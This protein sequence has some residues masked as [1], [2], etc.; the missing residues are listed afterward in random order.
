M[1]NIIFVISVLRIPR[2]YFLSQT[3]FF[4]QTDVSF[5][6]MSSLTSAAGLWIR[7]KRKKTLQIPSAGKKVWFLFLILL[8]PHWFEV[9]QLVSDAAVGARNN[10]K[11]QCG[12]KVF[13][14]LLEACRDFPFFLNPVQ[15]GT[16]APILILLLWLSSIR[17]WGFKVILGFC[18]CS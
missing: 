1:C 16:H 18:L 8:F 2:P 4:F 9:I 10:R 11:L 13:P 3:N 5:Q 17:F 14:V 15:K 12:L 7:I 6:T